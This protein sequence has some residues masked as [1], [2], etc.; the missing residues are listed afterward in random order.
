MEEERNRKDKSSSRQNHTQNASE[1]QSRV[2]ASISIATQTV[3]C[4]NYENAT[5]NQSH[6]KTN[7]QTT[8]SLFQ[9]PNQ[10]FWAGLWTAIWTERFQNNIK[11]VY[12][13]VWGLSTTLRSPHGAHVLFH[14][15]LK[16]FICCWEQLCHSLEQKGCVPGTSQS[17]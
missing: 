7:Y 9:T 5:H 6:N 1:N 12:E 3:A 10:N 2:L 17:S 16:R 13:Q 15:I 11:T 14:V 8:Q 4:S